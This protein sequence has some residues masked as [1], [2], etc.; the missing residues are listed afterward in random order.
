MSEQR[1]HT[2]NTSP[3]FAEMI[4][5]ARKWPRNGFGEGC[6]FHAMADWMERARADAQAIVDDCTFPERAKAFARD[7]LSDDEV[8]RG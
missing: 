5:Q 6:W 7:V 2:E 4:E 1:S 8:T 3:T